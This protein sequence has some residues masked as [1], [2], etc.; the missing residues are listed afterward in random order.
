MVHIVAL[1]VMND[2]LGAMRLYEFLDFKV[3]WLKKIRRKV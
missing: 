2:N 1:R 3:I